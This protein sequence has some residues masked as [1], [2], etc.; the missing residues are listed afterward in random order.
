MHADQKDLF[1]SRI[2]T[3]DVNTCN[4]DNYIEFSQIITKIRHVC[5]L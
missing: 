1:L 3:L 4:V 5:N 2:T